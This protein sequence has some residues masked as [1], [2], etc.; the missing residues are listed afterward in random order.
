MSKV[1]KLNKS[2]P[3][4]LDS[5]TLRRLVEAGPPKRKRGR[6]RKNPQV[7]ASDNT[8]KVIK[9][10][11]EGIYEYVDDLRHV[12]LCPVCKSPMSD[13]PGTPDAICK[14]CGYKDPCCE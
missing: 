7:N 3:P 5:S 2:G 11:V 12:Q 4:R 8:P 9:T 10:R 13:M 14:N 6:P 1:T